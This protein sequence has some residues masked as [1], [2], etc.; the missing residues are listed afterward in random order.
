MNCTK[1]F[2][3][4]LLLLIAALASSSSSLLAQS[5]E[6]EMA[7]RMRADGKIWVVVAVLAIIFAG[8]FA[9]LIRLDRKLTRLE[10]EMK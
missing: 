7:D 6:P 3:R 5:S 9:Y 2:S 10:R 1:F 8:I 4:L